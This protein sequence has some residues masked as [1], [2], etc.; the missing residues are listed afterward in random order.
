MKFSQKGFAALEGILILIIIAIIGG[1]GYYVWHA[2]DQADETLAETS[3][4]SASP[5]S[6]TSA[7]VKTEDD[8]ADWYKYQSPDDIYSI[9]LAD[10]WQLTRPSS[11]V[12][13]L[14]W[15]NAGI[16][17]KKGTPAKVTVEDGGRDGPIP[18]I[19]YVVGHDGY[20]SAFTRGEKQP[21]FKTNQGLNV[22]KHVFTQAVEPEGPDLPRGGKS[23]TYV[24]SSGKTTVEIGHDEVPGDTDNVGLIE[25]VIK[26]LEIN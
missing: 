11:G 20:E 17:Y 3:N 22:D 18:F 19:L 10:G 23:Y 1:T 2:K 12:T 4:S 16:T 8:T 14:G 24:I 25:K 9:R 5:S 26:T 15:S 13:L 7:P 21:G 6:K